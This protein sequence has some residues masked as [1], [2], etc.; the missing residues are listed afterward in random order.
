MP[1]LD[2]I[3]SCLLVTE[4]DVQA[5]LG[6]SAAAR[7]LIERMASVARPNQGAARILAVL[8]RFD[9]L[10]WLDGRLRVEVGGDAE[11]CVIDVLTQLGGGFSERVWP[12]VA[13]AVPLEELRRAV[14]MQ[15][16]F[17]LPLKLK[18]DRRNRLVLTTA[19]DQR[20]SSLPPP[21]IEVGDVALVWGQRPASEIIALPELPPIDL[22]LPPLDQ[23]LA[24]SMSVQ[25]MQEAPAQQPPAAQPRG[26]RPPV[27]RPA[28]RPTPATG[29][30]GQGKSKGHPAASRPKAAA[31]DPAFVDQE[32]ATLRIKRK[33]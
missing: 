28:P 16:R 5:A 33:G 30:A 18:H 15:P 13:V 9:G 23:L 7:G 11:V 10:D 24:P 20:S 25:G 4:D 6:S 27:R 32:A 12:T 14:K 26:D 19:T 2:H 31:A 21:I 17:I 3:S 1:A 22:R 8:A 29:P